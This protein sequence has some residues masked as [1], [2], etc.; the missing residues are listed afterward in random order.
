MTRFSHALLLA[1][2][3]LLL[4]GCD[5]NSNFFSWLKGK[6]SL[7]QPDALATIEMPA[8]NEPY[9]YKT[10]SG[11]YLAGRYAQNSFDWSTAYDYL[12]GIIPLD[13]S[14]LDLKRRA[15][16]LAMGAG[17][18][19]Q[20]F[21]SARDLARLGDTGS[22]PRLFLTL[23]TFKAAK[24]S[25]VL[26]DIAAVPEDGISEFINPLIQAWAKA[27]QGQFDAAALTGN[28]VHIYHAILIADYLGNEEALK[29]L[30]ERDYTKMNLAPKSVE[31]IADIFARHKLTAAAQSLYT[32]LRNSDPEEA[33]DITVKMTA[34]EKGTAPEIDADDKI[35]SP[36]DG[37]S[38]A[39]FDMASVLYSEYE[40]SS[41]LFA[42]MSLYLNPHMT[43]SRIL[44]GHMAARYDRYDEAITFYQQ[45]DT[46]RDPAMQVK[47][48]R[49]IAEL[50]AQSDRV[51]QAIAVLKKL[52]KTTDS[53]DAQIQLGD[54]QRH[55]ED[56]PAA[57]REYNKAFAMLKDQVPQK[58]WNLIY[59]RGMTNERLKNWDQAEKDLKAALA[60][61]PD[62]PYILNYLGY[63]WADQGVNLDK[64]AEMIARAVALR[65]NDGFIVDSL[66]WV[67]YRMGKYKEAAET[68][69]K[70]IEL[71]PYDP[72]LNDHLGDAYWR[73]GRKVEARF[74]W[75]RAV[76]FSKEQ[77]QIDE[78]SGKIEN[79]L[80]ADKSLPAK[81]S[82]AEA[83]QKQ[84]QK[85]ATDTDKTQSSQP[86]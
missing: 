13:Q 54:I 30:T 75:R 3:A 33:A 37:L 58:Y 18:Y 40:D 46:T 31:R 62:H 42:Q 34:L 47:L 77:E 61:E 65:P 63:S 15:M 19:D 4:S 78:I 2:T 48:Q 72:T 24:Y 16:V 23:E 11:S 85:D 8:D 38:K 21:A 50:L 12:S 68:L 80:T 39:L 79:G 35:T 67:Y 84:A 69:E 81:K 14:N 56:Y 60:Y 45:I 29:K 32:Y 22:L 20:S 74:Q 57:L 64:A 44:L 26:K 53:V 86:R 27:G 76:S 6:L 82:A 59:A 55:K 7:E 49:Q 66:G 41:R 1:S 36:I 5:D 25:D 10:F 73:V 70:A 83:L 52:V 17:H 51:D 9:P 71:M 28:V 43:D